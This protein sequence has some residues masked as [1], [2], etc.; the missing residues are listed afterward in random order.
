[1]STDESTRRRVLQGIGVT[2][3]G[4]AGVSNANAATTTIGN[5]VQFVEAVLDYTVNS[6]SPDVVQRSVVEIDNPKGFSVNLEEQKIVFNQFA[7]SGLVSEVKAA[8]EAVATSNQH[9]EANFDGHQK[10]QYLVTD[11]TEDLRPLRGVLT[12]RPFTPP[13]FKAQ[14]VGDTVRFTGPQSI[15]VP[16]GRETSRNLPEREV[17]VKIRPERSSDTYPKKSIEQHTVTPVITVRN[18][19]SLEI[20]KVK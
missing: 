6:A 14:F 1:M 20:H 12:K 19:G 18:H 5:S 10:M 11:R 3:L 17:V 15:E 8:E 4:F 16:V 7:R 9:L 2:G 13:Q